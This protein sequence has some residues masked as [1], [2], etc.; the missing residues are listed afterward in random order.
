MRLRLALVLSALGSAPMA[1]Q[2]LE[3]F[4][5]VIAFDSLPTGLFTKPNPIGMIGSGPVYYALQADP[6]QSG[7][8]VGGQ[9]TLQGSPVVTG[10]QDVLQGSTTNRW[11]RIQVNS[12]AGSQSAWILCRQVQDVKNPDQACTNFTVQR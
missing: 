9:I 3:P 10:Q 12:D 7:H 8:T 5:N 6:N 4:G 2:T 1:A 11:L